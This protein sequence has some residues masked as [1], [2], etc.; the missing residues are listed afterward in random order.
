MTQVFSLIKTLLPGESSGEGFARLPTIENTRYSEQW[1]EEKIL[2]VSA[3]VGGR[4]ETFEL[5][6]PHAG[7]ISP[8]PLWLIS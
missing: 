4:M 2:L 1:V 6:S 5:Q 7:A 8:G 3:Q